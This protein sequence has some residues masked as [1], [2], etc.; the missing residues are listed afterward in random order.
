M[1]SF[2]LPVLLVLVAVVLLVVVMTAVRNYIKVPPNKV[3]VFY[4]RRRRTADGAN[5]GFRLVTGGAALKWPILES[6]SYLDLT[7]FPID[8]DVRDVPNK[9][10]VLVSVQARGQR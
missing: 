6:V 1:P 7:I 10:G 8:L 2:I 4:G 5:V 3:A 9:D